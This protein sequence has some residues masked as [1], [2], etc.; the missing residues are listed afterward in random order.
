[1]RIPSH[2]RGLSCCC[3]KPL[4]MF[5]QIHDREWNHTKVHASTCTGSSGLSTYCTVTMSLMQCVQTL[6]DKVNKVS[7]WALGRTYHCSCRCLFFK[8]CTCTNSW[9]WLCSKTWTS[10]ATTGT[11]DTMIQSC[12]MCQC[13]VWTLVTLKTLVFHMW[14]R[15]KFSWENQA[16]KT[17]IHA[18]WAHELC[19]NSIKNQSWV[20]DIRIS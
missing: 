4:R 9:L 2:P 11:W 14:W 5:F 16:P 1:M 17:C 12:Y 7:D 15:R 20:M 18:M 19:P 8:I 6:A 13:V 3:L 10:Y